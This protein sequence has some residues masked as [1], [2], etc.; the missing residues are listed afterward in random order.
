MS[1]KACPRLETK[2]HLVRSSDFNEMHRGHQLKQPQY[3]EAYISNQYDL[4]HYHIALWFLWCCLAGSYIELSR[5][6][7]TSNPVMHNRRWRGFLRSGWT[8][9]VPRGNRQR[10]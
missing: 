8:A 1:R 2:T 5:L 3:Q 4:W 9:S 7:S 6:A 10:N